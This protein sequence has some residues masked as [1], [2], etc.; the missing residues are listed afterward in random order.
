MNQPVA[1][2]IHVH[3]VSLRGGD[4]G[5]HPLHNPQSRVQKEITCGKRTLRREV[6]ERGGS[7]EAWYGGD[8]PRREATPCFGTQPDCL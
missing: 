8:N 7:S 1:I 5:T 3:M 2:I 4:K 6:I